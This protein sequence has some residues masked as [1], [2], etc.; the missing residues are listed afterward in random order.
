MAHTKFYERFGYAR[1]LYHLDTGAAPA[2][3]EIAREIGR[4]GPA[5]SGWMDDENPPTD[6]RVHQPLADFLGVDAK[7][8]ISDVGEAPRPQLWAVWLKA[9]RSERATPTLDRLQKDPETS[10]RDYLKSAKKPTAKKA[11]GGRGRAG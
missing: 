9:R 11:N 8:L 3:A 10:V 5:V 2:H 7:W 1:W 4:T 6:Y